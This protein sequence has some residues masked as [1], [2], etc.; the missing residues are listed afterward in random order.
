MVRRVRGLAQPQRAP[1]RGL[2]RR[3][4]AERDEADTVDGSGVELPELGERRC[5]GGSRRRR[6]HLASTPRAAVRRRARNGGIPT[7][8][9]SSVRDPAVD[10]RPLVAVVANV[11]CPQPRECAVATAR[12]RVTA[13]HPGT[14]LMPASNAK[15]MT[16]VAALEV[17]GPDHRF[18]TSVETLGGRVGRV[19]AA[20]ST[21]AVG[22]S[23]GAGGRL[24]RARRSVPAGS[25]GSSAWPACGSRRATPPPSSGARS[26]GTVCACSVPPP[27]GPRRPRPAPSRWDPQRRCPPCSPRSSSAGYS[28]TPAAAIPW[29]GR[30]SP[31]GPGAAVRRGV[32][33]ECSWTRS[34]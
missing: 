11:P 25:P 13:R 26:R 4:V 5:G 2:R 18:R 12:R 8:W 15:L 16:S 30:L 17:L 9:T 22:R 7:G 1:R 23:H 14:R 10:P 34:C 28:R 20:T 21:C 33:V 24:R 29:R 31:R 27:P 3:R 6:W 19:V 32:D